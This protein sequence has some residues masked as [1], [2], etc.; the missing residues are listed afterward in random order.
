[1]R[2]E[3]LTM[4]AFGPYA[5][6]TEIPFEKFG[7]QGIYLITGDTG[8]GKT[9]VF[10][11][12]VF[13]LYGEAS[14][15]SRRPDMMRSDF[16]APDEKTYV[17]LVFSC[18][19][20]TYRVLRN[21]EYQR[22]KARGTGMTKEAADAVL[23]YPDG[24]TVTGSRAVTRASEEILG[25]DR[26]Q[27]VQI[28]MIAQGDFLRL[29]LAG[30]EE[31]AKIFRKI[32]DTGLYVSF[33]DEL[34][35]RMKEA[36]T[37]YEEAKRRVGQYAE[38]I[39]FM[40]EEEK[41]RESLH[42]ENSPGNRLE[43]FEQEEIVYRLKEYTELLGQ[44]IGQQK[45][46]RAGNS[47][48]ISLLEKKL[49]D[50]QE[51]LGACRMALQA[52]KDR[53]EKEKRIEKLTLEQR[54]WERK[55]QEAS[56]GSE[57]AKRLRQE[58][59]GLILQMKE[60]QE[61]EEQEAEEKRLR[62]EAERAEK[63][64]QEYE[65]RSLKKQQEKEAFQNRLRA[66]G[67][68]EQTLSVLEEKKKREESLEKRLGTL[69]QS[70]EEELS[71]RKELRKREEEYCKAR[72]KSLLLGNE[73]TRMEAAFFD[74]QAG[75]LAEKLEEGKPCPVCG[76][77]IHPSPASREERIPTEEELKALGEKREK[78]SQEMAGKARET[79]ALKGESGQALAYLRSQWEELGECEEEKGEDWIWKLQT[80]M[81]E[82][83]ESVKQ[84]SLLLEKEIQKTRKLKE[85]KKA[86]EEQ[87]P[88]CEKEAGELKKK[89]EKRQLE[90][91]AL[92]GREESVKQSL[93][94]LKQKLSFP[95]KKEAEEHLKEVQR[96]AEGLE[97]TLEAARKGLEECRR[98]LEGEQR[99][100][101]AL[102]KQ[103]LS[104]EAYQGETL[105]QEVLKCQEEKEELRKRQQKL[106][107]I[108]ETN[109][110]ILEK[111][112]KSEKEIKK[113]GEDYAG[114]ALLSDTA[115]GELKGKP[116][117]AFEQY[118]QASFF[119]RIIREANK[120]LSFM[121]NGRYLLK[122]REDPESLRSQT[123]LELDVFD[124]YTGKLRSVQSLSGGESFKASLSMAL[125][126]SD[127]VQQY[128]G[129]IQLD[130]IFVDEGFGSLDRES[131]NQAMGILNELAGENRMV[132]I[133]SHVEELK[134]R[135]GKK[136]VVY[137]EMGGSRL[138]V[139]VE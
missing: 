5:G 40:E 85:E 100:A 29:L 19:G 55:Y 28:A 45:Q 110:G 44:L 9:T 35:R 125:G 18:R 48:E 15:S 53:K 23:T 103:A 49:A 132:G 13:A 105:E 88:E 87:I 101:E 119:N 6:R 3:R 54:E 98:N 117:L 46:E 114:I 139:V 136:I 138:E 51:R 96:R 21:P 74:G 32:F 107:T 111:I 38:G 118:I 84:N 90:A 1:M 109:Q 92:K 59:S 50:L 75:I 95:G 70:L 97:E 82:K 73:Y 69:K 31:R 112:G 89:A 134:E 63:E 102:K 126:L 133:I 43:S 108:L 78:A 99:A 129:G 71:R 80:W 42:R 122:R 113:A 86:L 124:H 131:L 64:G 22:P 39:L 33:Q 79:A 81:E 76:S 11:A 16:A 91:A 36:K 12:I 115:N 123:G 135:I 68:P 2:P 106:T 14:G 27:F 94:K 26:N 61:A 57:E 77:L 4:C 83:R 104:Q 30:T 17:E 37:V 120:R 60:Y 8:A 25:I 7:A 127:V 67:D 130:T 52:E 41:D 58:A 72:E 66:I 93:M 65:S 34:K 121:T 20:E 56:K 128:A 10:D 137:R 116:K 62:E 24:R 47:R